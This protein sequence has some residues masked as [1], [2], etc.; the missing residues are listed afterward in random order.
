MPGFKA[1]RDSLTVSL[2]ANAAGNFKLKP[3]LIYHSENARALKN[4][5]KSTLPMRYTWNN[6]AWMTAHLFKTWFT[7]YFKS[8]VEAYC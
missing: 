5:V 2:G 6:K 4:Y 7:E 8:T 1:S 3:A